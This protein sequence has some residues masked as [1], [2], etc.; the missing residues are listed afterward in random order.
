M[1]A[2]PDGCLYVTQDGV[3]DDQGDPKPDNSIV[4][5]CGGF[6]PPAGITPNPCPPPVISGARVTPDKL[7]PPNGR[8]VD[9]KVDYT[10]SG[11]CAGTSATVMLSI[12]SN[13]GGPSD[14]QIVNLHLVRLR[15]RREGGRSDRIY[16]ITIT[17]TDP[18]GGGTT[19]KT[20]QVV[21][22]HD[23]G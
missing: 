13:E 17:A 1:Q 5:I 16:T 3:Y 22:P 4:Q 8:M 9:V 14:W 10:V 18:A 2:G 21:V 6:A 23:Q 19:K 7:W 15:A 12:S 20:V 11:G